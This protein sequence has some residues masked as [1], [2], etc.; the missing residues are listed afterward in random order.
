[1]QKKKVIPSPFL[2]KRS[3][4]F[5]QRQ[6]RKK[7]KRRGERRQSAMSIEK[8]RDSVGGNDLLHNREKKH[9]TEIISSS[10]STEGE[11]RRM[12]SKK[13]RHLC[14]RSRGSSLAVTLERKRGP[15]VRAFAQKKGKKTMAKIRGRK[16]RVLLSV[17]S[18][19][20]KILLGI[21]G[22]AHRIEGVKKAENGRS[23]RA[24]RQ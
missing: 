13:N 20:A 14:R 16:K 11:G 4:H 24:L 23:M 22:S 7:K 9:R 18:P 12:V 8:N 21:S 17:P 15:N 1:M 19:R 5:V 3:I 2:E 6:Q 10:R